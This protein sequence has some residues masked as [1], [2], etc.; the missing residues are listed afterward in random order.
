M[1]CIQRGIGYLVTIFLI[2][3][4]GATVL[5]SEDDVRTM[6]DESRSDDTSRTS[7]FLLPYALY[8]SFFPMSE[9]YQIPE[10]KKVEGLIRRAEGYE[11]EKNYEQAVKYYFLAAK[12]ATGSAAS[13]Y[14]RYKGCALE[15]NGPSAILCLTQL[16]QE[17]PDFPLINGVRYELA[18]RAF[19]MGDFD[20]ALPVLAEIVESEADE[21]TFTPYVYTFMGIIHHRK[22]EEE[23]ALRNFERSI[24]L[25]RSVDGGSGERFMQNYIETAKSLIDMEE[26]AQA[27]YLLVRIYG[28]AASADFQSE[29]LFLLARLYGL[30]GS[31]ALSA[32]ALY[33]IVQDYPFS[34]FAPAARNEL[35]DIEKADVLR[36]SPVNDP[37][38]LNGS[39]VYAS[40]TPVLEGFGVQIGSFSSGKNADGLVQKLKNE[41]LPAL[42][43][44]SS[45]E[46]KNIFRVYIGFFPS[47]SEA[48][49]MKKKLKSIGYD[50][51]VVHVD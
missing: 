31:G 10:E 29:S 16:I 42:S 18:R 5:N 23:E 40:E 9:E 21:I 13:P 36:I 2:F 28:T 15:A 30:N 44:Q 32:S 47:R 45:H 6:R 14:I 12:R 25:H 51:F 24:G 50:G 11:R 49:D 26:Y 27:E 35:G 37:S 20:T 8:S 39:Y 48:D 19:M 33:T 3:V 41:G 34:P 7:Y 43:V 1:R 22:G 46:D 4:V 38:L 17:H